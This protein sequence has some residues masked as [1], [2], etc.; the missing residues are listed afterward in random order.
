RVTEAAG[1]GS[2]LVGDPLFAAGPTPDSL[3][4][5]ADLAARTET[6]R[7]G[8]AVLQ[9]GL[10]EPVAAGKQIATIDCLSGGRFIL[11]VGAGGEFA[12]EWAAA[13]VPRA[14]RGHPL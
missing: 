4:L 14:D 11:G 12:D 1:F 2:L 13:N 8:T 10:R 9:L 3:A 7:I 5:A 6:I